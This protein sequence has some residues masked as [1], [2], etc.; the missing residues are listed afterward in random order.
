MNDQET[1][2]VMSIE[3]NEGRII[4]SMWCY[5]DDGMYGCRKE[6]CWTNRLISVT[7]ELKSVAPLDFDDVADCQISV[8][9]KVPTIWCSVVSRVISKLVRARPQSS[10]S[11]GYRDMLTSRLRGLDDTLPTLQ[12][13]TSP[14]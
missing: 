4:P 11:D 7:R 6:P 3:G 9:T 8:L 10:F 1:L 14:S 2:N 13:T 5:E 12:V